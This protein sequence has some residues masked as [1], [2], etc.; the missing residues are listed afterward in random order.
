MKGLCPELAWPPQVRSYLTVRTCGR[1]PSWESRYVQQRR[2]RRHP[3]TIAA[4]YC[5]HIVHLCRMRLRRHRLQHR[6]M[7]NTRETRRQ[8]VD[9][10]SCW[11]VEHPRQRRRLDRRLLGPP[12]RHRRAPKRSN[13]CACTPGLDEHCRQPFIMVSDSLWWSLVVSTKSTY[14]PTSYLLQ[15]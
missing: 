7:A 14:Y 5:F 4:A 8:L 10:E 6:H 3:P 13:D 2:K 9:D 12:L 15:L 1:E 11:E